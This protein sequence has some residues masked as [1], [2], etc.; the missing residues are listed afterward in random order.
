MF[1]YGQTGS[2]KTYTM[3]GSPEEPGVN[4]RALNELFRL[5]AKNAGTI[6]Y[7]I[8]LSFLEIYCEDIRDLLID[9]DK[10]TK[11]DIKMNPNGGVYIP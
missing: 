2:G 10:R 7:S 4:M 8:R 5:K 3:M 9:V 6:N 1:A 11:L